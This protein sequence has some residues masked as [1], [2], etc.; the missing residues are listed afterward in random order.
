MLA[1]GN[2]KDRLYLLERQWIVKAI[3]GLFCQL[4]WVE[5]LG[6]IESSPWAMPWEQRNHLYLCRDLKGTLRDLWPKVKKWR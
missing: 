3:C 2:L 4:R 6:P 1:A 5:D